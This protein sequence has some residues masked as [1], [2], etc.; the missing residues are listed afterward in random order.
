MRIA[1]DT[2]GTFTDLVIDGGGC[3]GMFKAPTTPQ[4][5]VRG[6]LEVVEVAADQLSTTVEELLGQCETFI[7][8]TTHAI[9]A[10]VTGKTAKTAL[11]T[12]RGHPDILVL[13]EGGR[14]DPF[15][16]K[17]SYPKPYVPKSLTFEVSERIS[18][19]GSIFEPLH[20]A[21][22][23][24]TIE[25]L[26]AHGVETVAVCLLWSTINSIHEVRIG[27][28]LSEYLPGVPYT[29]SHRLNPVL[30]EYRRASST[31]IDASLKPLMTKYVGGL[32]GRLE[33]AGFRGR[34]LMLTSKGGV[35]DAEDLAHA[36]IHVINSGPS[37]AP[38]A[39]HYFCQ[40]DIGTSTAIIA[41]TGG[42]TYDVSLV[43]R[44]VIP[45]TPDTWIGTRSAGH[46]IGFPSVDVK[47][48]GAGGGSI[49]RVD[50]GGLLHVGPQSASAVPGPACYGK[51]GTSATVTDAALVLGHLDPEFFLGGTMRLDHESAAQAIDRDVARPLRMN[52]LE[53]ASAVIRLATE[54]MVSAIEQITIHQG[55]DPRGSVLVGGG[56]AAGLNSVS[57][58][59]RLG[60]SKVLFPEAGAALSAVGA[61]ISDLHADYRA[62]LYT[63]TSD[64]DFGGAKRI[65]DG[66]T[67]K[68][69]EFFDGPG[70]GALDKWI[71]YVVEARYRAQIWEI[72]V[73]LE[74]L[75]NTRE[76]L[77]QLRRRFDS[78][79]K[80][81]FGY[82]DDQSPV[83]FL[84][85]RATARCRLSDQ[86]LGRLTVS[87][88]PKARAKRFRDAFFPS[89]G[90]VQ[91]D[92]H[93]FE[94]LE[95]GSSITGPAIVESSF[96]TVVIDP[97]AKVER[98]ES[99]SLL[100]SP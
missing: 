74:R 56:G 61:L 91:T 37:M 68:C 40:K 84:G 31:A 48:I 10:I 32:A 85:W 63:E 24:E 75:P 67:E 3:I 76:E 64:F 23:V 26:G 9:N 90:Q 97:G 25:S 52:L 53:A 88:K 44:G 71:T 69:Q 82:Q 89:V 80:E 87:S 47:S 13:R 36:P 50:E 19:D 35:M 78:V 66:L 20:E 1:C 79:H 28:L 46:I 29:L 100:V 83:Q 18:A 62:L 27:E 70:E 30:R 96:T 39:G 60:C 77:T 5:P 21:E 6:I 2:G 11:L 17:L 73:P 4:D 41:D 94:S 34:L 65:V 98:T 54:N 8:G 16:T 49:A 58:A 42:T 43:R 22:L 92:V 55:V 38:I 93:S 95:V 99:G 33:R 45:M 72:D 59:R 81:I 57:I 7:H 12:T 14:L 86:G 51:G 15:N